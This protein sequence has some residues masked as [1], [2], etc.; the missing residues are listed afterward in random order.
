MRFGFHVSVAGGFEKA[1]QRAVRLDCST[2]QLFAH[3]PRSWKAKA[4]VSD[5]ARAFKKILAGAAI[6]PVSVHMPYLPNPATGDRGLMAKSVNT[7]RDNLQSASQLGAR[8]LVVHPGNSGDD[9]AN[10]GIARAVHC[11]AEACRGGDRTVEILLENTAGQGSEIGCDFKQLAM[12]LRMLG[13]QYPVG[14]C[15][16]T[17]HAF[18][19]GYDLS[20][21]GAVKKTI[22]VLEDTI[23]LSRVKLIHLNDTKVPLGS[24]KDRHW[25]IGKGRI[26]KEGF[27]AFLQHP[28]LHNLPA[29]METPKKND[30][31]ERNNMRMARR[32]AGIQKG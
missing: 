26:G 30:A 15:L 29:V 3:N 27:T 19:A 8:Y 4:I 6:E 24:H 31:D 1:A 14:V 21:A 11:L 12:M 25:H 10:T 32:L 7:V 23:G 9:D 22:A 28:A 5:D 16:D 18:A 2:I 13:S 17:A 20:S